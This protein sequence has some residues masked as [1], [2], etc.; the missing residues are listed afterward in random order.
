MGA[1]PG[2]RRGFTLIEL[3][4]VI[5]IIAI[6][7]GL[8]VPAVQKVR[9]AAARIQNSNNLK[10]CGLAV[11][12]YHDTFKFLPYNG[13][14]NVWGNPGVKDTGS[15]C[16]QILPFIEQQ[17]VWTKA[18]TLFAAIPYFQTAAHKTS[19]NTGAATSGGGANPSM[20]PTAVVAVFLD[21][22]R[23]RIGFASTG[24]NA[25]S[26]TD[27]AI[28]C[29]IEFGLNI[30]SGG[31]ARRTLLSIQRGTSNIVF[32]GEACLDISLY[33]ATSV[34]GGSW[35]ETWWSGGYG[36]SGREGFKCIQDNV[37]M[38]SSYTNQWG[39]PYPGAAQFLF[40]DGG[41]RSIPYGTDLTTY[42]VT[43]STAPQPVIPD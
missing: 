3:L 42:M 18:P 6:L 17:N 5:A 43:T 10:Q 2:R 38:G 11:H 20:G 7:I 37:N 32:A 22:G 36:G 1:L 28:N 19:Y 31:N 33:T 35:N 13:K 41:V 40:C 8:L 24:Q 25:G 12:S 4:V 26:Q 15:W 21:P 27:Y 14:Y 16:C 23:G 34:W 9:V 30:T 39:G 29:N